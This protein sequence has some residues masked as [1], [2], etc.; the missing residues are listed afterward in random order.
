MKVDHNLISSD[1]TSPGCWQKLITLTD[2]AKMELLMFSSQVLPARDANK[3]YI[4]Y[5]AVMVYMHSPVW[6]GLIH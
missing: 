2:P 5:P 1:G 3:V 4:Q 6:N